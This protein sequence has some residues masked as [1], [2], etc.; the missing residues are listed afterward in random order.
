MELIAER[1]VT[2][3]I[4]LK[5]KGSMANTNQ[6]DQFDVSHEGTENISVTLEITYHSDIGDIIGVKIRLDYTPTKNQ[7]K[8]KWKVSWMCAEMCR[9]IVPDELEA[10]QLV[11]G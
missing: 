11:E 8:A 5:N 1:G 9:K 7:K 6:K 10:G 3:L 4:E 2:N